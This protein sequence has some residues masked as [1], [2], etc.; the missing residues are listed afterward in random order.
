MPTK[1]QTTSPDTSEG[2][3]NTTVTP[4]KPA[5]SADQ[6][7]ADLPVSPTKEPGKK[8][9]VLQKA[10]LELKSA[11]KEVKEKTP[12]SLTTRTHRYALEVWIKVETSPGNFTPPEE[13]LYSADFVLDTLNLTYPGCTGVFL[14]EPGHAIAFYGQK[15][16]VRAGLTVEQ[17][18]KACK[19]ISSI[20]VWMGYAAKIK[21]R[22]ISLQEANDMI[23]GLKRLNK[24][25]L[26]KARMELHHWLSSWRLRN[27]GSNLSTTAQPFVPLATSSNTVVRPLGA[28][29]APAQ[30]PHTPQTDPVTHTPYTSEDE[31]ATTEAVTPKKKNRKRGSRG[32]RSKQGSQTETCDSSSETASLSSSTGVSDSLVR[33]RCNKKKGG[34]NNKVHIL[35]FDGKTSNS[36]GAGKAFRRWSRSISYYRDCY[37]DEYLMAQIIGALK[38]DAAGV[39]DFACNHGKKHTKDL[40]LILE[41]MWHHYCGTLTFREQWNGGFRGSSPRG[42]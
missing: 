13:E 23:V 18:T 7:L 38:G 2:V 30:T 32:K 3:S 19:L 31:G 14:A 20:P 33:G 1:S 21:A 37:E 35:E 12:P 39:F 36:E 27:T 25:D 8:Q 5:P 24:E 10:Q 42:A 41:Q 17:S 4:P 26:R 15:G 29:S 11:A 6:G 40:G 28:A 16:S 22:A 34:V 9:E